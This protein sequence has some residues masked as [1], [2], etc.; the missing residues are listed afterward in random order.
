MKENYKVTTWYQLIYDWC[1]KEGKYGLTIPYLVG[2]C[3]IV[4]PENKF[5]IESLLKEIN[6]K[7]FEQKVIISYCNDLDEYIVGF[8]VENYPSF[9]SMK[10]YDNLYLWDNDLEQKDS[11]ESVINYLIDR[12]ESK[13]NEGHYS[14]DYYTLKWSGF[15]ELEIV[16]IKNASR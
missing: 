6:Q 1:V 5:K 16:K 14:K 11:L 9:D 12:Y 7:E 13:I 15:D 3:E 2:A 8:R 4:E 10:K